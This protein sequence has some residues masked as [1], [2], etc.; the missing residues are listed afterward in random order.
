MHIPVAQFVLNL[1]A[2]STASQQF[3]AL[4]SW[5]LASQCHTCMLPIFLYGSLV[6]GSYQERCTQDRCSPSM[7]W[8]LLGIKWCHHYI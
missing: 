4:L 1:F 8:K 7:M 2:A 3:K 6:L 5:Y